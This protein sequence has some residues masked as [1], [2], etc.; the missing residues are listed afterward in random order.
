MR[1]VDALP[2]LCY[3]KVA[4]ETEEGRRLNIAPETL[5]SHL[6]YFS[7]RGL[8]T[9]RARDL[10]LDWPEKSVC[11]TFDD[12]YSSTLTSGIEVL[13]RHGA[14]ASIYAVGALIGR[15]SEWDG[16]LASPLADGDLLRFAAE[17]GFE[18]GNHSDRHPR[19]AEL[20][21]EEQ[22]VELERG[23]LAL[24]DLGI[25]AASMAFPYG[26]FNL[27]TREALR[28]AGYG[29]GLALGRRPARPGDDRLALP[30]I[31][32]GFGDRLPLLLYKLHLKWRLPTTRRRPGYV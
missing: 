5:S 6:N 3:H 12:A 17:A 24:V 22:L 19:L 31:V 15:R 2:I 4:P 32:I 25:V 13:Q 30:R 23:H 29:V 1:S 8:R 16:D 11:L 28:R 21:F 20:A 14:T 9:V 26:S 7:R 18:I 27:Q 10:A